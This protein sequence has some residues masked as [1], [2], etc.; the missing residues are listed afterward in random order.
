MVAIVRK[1]QG[2]TRAANV[3]MD[4]AAVVTAGENVVVDDMTTAAMRSEST[5]NAQAMEVAYGED[6]GFCI[7]CVEASCAHV[8]TRMPSILNSACLKRIK[9]N[10]GGAV[11]DGRI[12]MEGVYRVLREKSRR[13]VIS[14]IGLFGAAVPDDTEPLPADET[15][16]QILGA[17]VANNAGGG[18]GRGAA[19]GR[20]P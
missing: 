18:G 8:N 13:G 5:A 15:M 14:G 19:G 9:A 6:V 2:V 11:S 4:I 1:A 12:H 7:G 3:S 10:H 16:A 20:V 17:L